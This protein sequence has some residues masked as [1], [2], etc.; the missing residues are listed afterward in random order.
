MACVCGKEKDEWLKG[1]WAVEAKADSH[2]LGV[3]PDGIVDLVGDG[4]PGPVV[5]A[6]RPLILYPIK[7]HKFFLFSSLISHSWIGRSKF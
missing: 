7:S 1:K 2:R 6:L 3:V 4:S 5:M